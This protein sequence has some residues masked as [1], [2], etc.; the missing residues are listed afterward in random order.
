MLNAEVSGNEA[1]NRSDVTPEDIRRTARP[2]QPKAPAAQQTTPQ[3]AL[4]RI[5]FN[6]A[7]AQEPAYLSP[8]QPPSPDESPEAA[9]RKPSLVFVRGAESGAAGGA[10]MRSAAI[11]QSDFVTP[12]PPGTRLVVSVLSRL[13]LDSPP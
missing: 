1:V 6:P 2:G 11:E 8:Q 12:L 13:I 7:P 9:L 10:P 3:Y 4:S 5:D